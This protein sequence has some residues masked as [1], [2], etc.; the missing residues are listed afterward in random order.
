MFVQFRNACSYE[1]GLKADNRYAVPS[2]LAVPIGVRVRPPFRIYKVQSDGNPH[3]VEE[4]QTLD[5]AEARVRELG[6]VWPGKY[7][8]ENEETGQ[9][10]FISTRD[11]TKN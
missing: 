11:E 5:G 8:I 4:I 7:I 9:R 1:S 10:V 6:K 3:F 2:Y